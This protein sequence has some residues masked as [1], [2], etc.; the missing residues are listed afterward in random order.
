MIE[1][2]FFVHQ[3][4]VHAVRCV[5]YGAA[6]VRCDKNEAAQQLFS[7]VERTKCECAVYIHIFIFIAS[8]FI[9]FI[10]N[11]V[12]VIVVNHFYLVIDDEYLLT[13]FY[14]II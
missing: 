2:S 12:D 4:I 10:F 1:L 6:A 11:F 9:L 8:S 13:T 7:T 5:R 14:R 3:L